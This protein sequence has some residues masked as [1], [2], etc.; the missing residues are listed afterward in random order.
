MS[1]KFILTV[2]DKTHEVDCLTNIDNEQAEK[3]FAIGI[4]KVLENERLGT[5]MLVGI[6]A[7][8]IKHPSFYVSMA[9]QFKEQYK[10]RHQK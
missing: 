8:F 1:T 4:S 2:N 7:F 5:A 6:L 3:N 10:L 9:K